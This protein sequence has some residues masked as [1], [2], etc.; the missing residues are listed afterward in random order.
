MSCI[1]SL[2]FKSE[3]MALEAVLKETWKTGYLLVVVESGQHVAQV[4]VFV[5]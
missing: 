5:F 4:A 1:I 2:F 3:G